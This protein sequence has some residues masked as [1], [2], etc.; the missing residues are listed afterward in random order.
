M[1]HN[2]PFVFLQK[3]TN[4]DLPCAV[5]ATAWH[6]F[7]ILSKWTRICKKYVYSLGVSGAAHI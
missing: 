2:I 4:F 1:A 6:M 3:P 5:A 7:A